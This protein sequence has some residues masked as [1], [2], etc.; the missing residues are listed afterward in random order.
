MT[1]QVA[2][3]FQEHKPDL[4]REQAWHQS[5]TY[6][7]ACFGLTPIEW[8]CRL[9]DQ[10]YP[11]ERL[12]PLFERTDV[13]F[14]PLSRLLGYGW[15]Y[16]HTF[17]LNQ[18]TLDPRWETEGVVSLVLEQGSPQKILDLGTGSGCLLIS[19]LHEL[20]TAVG[21]GVDIS[22]RALDMAQQN[23]ERIKVAERALWVQSH[24]CEKMADKFDCIVANPPYIESESP[25]PREVTA[26]DPPQALYGGPKGT[27][28]YEEIIP[29]LSG[30]L[31]AEGYVVFEI[32][33]NQADVVCHLFSQ[34]GFKITKV[35]QDVAGK[36][37]YIVA[38]DFS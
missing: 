8:A 19:L 16:N 33:Y 27:Q 34:A 11:Y 20:P 17:Y 22:P 37:R 25:L 29:H 31:N 28:A 32:G 1:Q 14:T 26:W 2:L 23:A 15:F 38:H 12:A 21:V 35:F 9:H 4:S 3:F 13:S 24:W 18:D 7:Q 6:V 5:K 10:T 30:L 36:D